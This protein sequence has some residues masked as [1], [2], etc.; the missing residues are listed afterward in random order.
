LTI[1]PLNMIAKGLWILSKNATGIPS[2]NLDE[3]IYFLSL[4]DATK[5]NLPGNAKLMAIK[6]AVGKRICE[7]I[8]A[9]NESAMLAVQKVDQESMLAAAYPLLV[10]TFNLLLF[11]M[12]CAYPEIQPPPI[13]STSILDTQQS[14]SGLH[15]YMIHERSFQLLKRR[16]M[17]DGSDVPTSPLNLPTPPTNV[18]PPPPIAHASND[19][20]PPIASTMELAATFLPP[21][22]GPKL[23][24]YQIEVT[25]VE[26]IAQKW[27]LGMCISY[28]LLSEP[29]QNQLSK[30]PFNDT[31]R[32]TRTAPCSL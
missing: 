22:T 1:I 27:T 6:D 12:S 26:D 32:G 20:A 23:H 15:E 25:C 2:W 9:M 11:I 30:A 28:L 7:I 14:I 16:K 21:P 10:D 18:S 31:T 29:Y 8:Q 4:S 19:I 17:L 24:G 5:R 3:C 13:R